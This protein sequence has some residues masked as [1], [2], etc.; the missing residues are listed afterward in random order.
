[1][2]KIFYTLFLS[3]ILGITYSQN[4]TPRASYTFSNSVDDISGNNYNGTLFGNAL[5]NGS[6]YIGYN[7]ADYL[8]IPN[9]V[10][11][12]LTDFSISFLVNF[13]SFNTSQQYATNH[14]LSASHAGNAD[15]FAFAYEKLNDRL[16]LAIE[17]D[18]FSFPVTLSTSQWY[19]FNIVREGALL[20]FYI[21]G[22]LITT[23]TCTT[24]PLNV[25]NGGLLIGQEQDCVGGCFD[26]KQCMYGY[27]DNLLIYDCANTSA[28]RCD[29]NLG[30]DD[31][32]KGLNFN[33]FPNPTSNSITIE[34]EE[35]IDEISIYNLDGKIISTQPFIGNLLDV[36]KLPAGVYFIEALSEDGNIGR[37]KFIKKD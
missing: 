25:S 37:A 31:L 35:K 20:S 22:A 14:I 36:S 1:M 19:C 13:T 9:T 15:A 4:C 2:K 34:S 11:N 23:N 27:L 3:L 24:V 12:G 26:I 33:L 17:G 30:V 8:S 5:S 7:T 18:N 21:D 16:L 6:L 10:L 32:N 29:K 28:S